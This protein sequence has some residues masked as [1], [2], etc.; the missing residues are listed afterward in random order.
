MGSLELA[1]RV[2]WLRVLSV[3]VASFVVPVG[4]LVGRTVL[5]NE[6]TALGIVM[7]ATDLIPSF[8]TKLSMISD[9]G[10]GKRNAE[11]QAHGSADDRSAEAVGGWAQGGGHGERSGGNEEHDLCLEGKVRRHGCEPGAGSEATAG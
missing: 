6:M 9:E 2:W 7:L 3:L 1:S 10:K 5:G 4:F 8:G 11:E